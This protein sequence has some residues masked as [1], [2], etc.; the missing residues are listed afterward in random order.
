MCQYTALGVFLIIVLPGLISLTLIILLSIKIFKAKKMH[1]AWRIF[2]FILL[3]L[4]SYILSVF[5]SNL[6]VTYIDSIPFSNQSIWDCPHC[7][8]LP[9]L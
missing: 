1:I 4:L 6:T 3:L 9:C 5:M 7:G 8:N 2:L